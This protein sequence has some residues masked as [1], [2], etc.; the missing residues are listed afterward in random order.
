M[1]NENTFKKMLLVYNPRSGKQTIAR[2]LSNIINV[3][4]KGGYDVICHPTQSK[5]DCLEIT[6]K[7]ASEFDMVVIA[8]GDGTLNEAVNGFM[9]AGYSRSFGYI[10]SGSTNDFSHSV[11]IPIRPI[12][13]ARTI[14]D[15]QPV[16]CD[17]GCL[18]DRYFTYVAGFG[19][20][21]EV[22]YTTP[23]NFK[24]I[25]GFSAYLLEGIA[26]LS[27][28]ESF[29]ISFESDVR[30]GSGEY[31]LGL[32]TNT[33]HVAG[34]KNQILPDIKLDDGLFEVL[35]VKR[36][37]NLRDINTIAAGL[38]SKKLDSECIDCFKTTSITISSDTPISWTLDGENGGKSRLS[39]I[40]IH[41]R[42]VSVIC[43]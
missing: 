34:L 5:G 4:T 39:E 33:L 32:V 41:N 21:T 25:F 35:L 42:A 17:L 13:A 37:K 3:F 43:P 8:G 10:P 7:R 40:K 2:S 1:N 28:I 29:N 23:Q 6:S 36:P 16:L 20:L 19:T 12:D 9:K 38:L 15:G 22:S 27:Q 14:I 24:N 30:S 26:A 11:G 31:L 18:N